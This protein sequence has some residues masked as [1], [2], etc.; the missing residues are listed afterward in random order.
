[1]QNDYQ[2]GVCL[3]VKT[4]H[5]FLKTPNNLRQRENLH[6]RMHN[7]RKW[8]QGAVLL[9]RNPY[10][11]VISYWNHRQASNELDTLQNLERSLYTKKFR[12]FAREEFI[13]WQD[14]AFDWLVVSPE[15]LVIHYEDF[16][17]DTASELR[18]VHRYLNNFPV[19]PK[20]MKC[21]LNN[22]NGNFKRT[23]HTRDEFTKDPFEGLH[24]EFD[25]TILR[26]QDMLIAKGHAPMPLQK[27]MYMA[28]KP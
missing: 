17:D 6:F 8:G 19:D 18:R 28:K 4:H 20:R 15:L 1:M 26:V 3:F 9:I 12:D 24:E 16:V 22:P 14:I 23:G 10:K 25:A 13:I 2:Q 7:L 11:S 5:H 27:Y 21:I